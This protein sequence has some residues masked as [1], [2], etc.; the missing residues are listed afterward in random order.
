MK[1]KGVLIL[2]QL[3]TFCFG[4]VLVIDEETGWYDGQ[5]LILMFSSTYAFAFVIYLES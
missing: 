3:I 5:V 1:T 4:F 2:C